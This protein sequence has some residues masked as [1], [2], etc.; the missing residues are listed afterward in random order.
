MAHK[1]RTLLIAC[2][3]N[4]YV[5]EITVFVEF[6]VDKLREASE[7]GVQKEVYMRV[8]TRTR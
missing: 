4:S 5:G 7:Q 1:S 3:A 8:Q 2:K 6:I